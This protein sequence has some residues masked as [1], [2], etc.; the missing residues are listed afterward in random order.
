[1]LAYLKIEHILFHLEFVDSRF[2]EL[3]PISR[4]LYATG[5][6]N[7]L[8]QLES[9]LSIINEQMDTNIDMEDAY[10]GDGVLTRI[11]QNFPK[12]FNESLY[13]ENNQKDAEIN[14]MIDIFP[15]NKEDYSF[16]SDSANKFKTG[17]RYLCSEANISSRD[18]VYAITN[19]LKE[20]FSLIVSINHKKSNIKD[21]QYEDFWYTVLYRDDDLFPERAINDYEEWKEEHDYQDL[22]VLKD[23][24]TQ[25]ILKMLNSGVFNYDVKPVNRELDNSIIEIPEEALEEGMEIPED[26]KTER[27]RFSK[28]VYFKKDILCLDYAKLGKYIYKHFRELTDD[29]VDGLIYFDYILLHIHD[30]MA[31]CNPKLKVHLRFYE[32]NL[33]EEILKNA[34][35]VIESCNSLLTEEAEQQSFLTN[36]LKD[37]FYGDNK[38]EVQTKLKGQSKY[39]LLCRMLGMIKTTQ[40]AFRLE[41]TTA[42]LAEALSTVVKKPKKDSLDD[43][44]ERGSR[45]L[46]SKLSKWTTLYVMDKL[47][48]KSERLFMDIAQK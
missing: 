47:G 45:E 38:I 35:T 2:E 3:S 37:A 9:Q 20:V 14:K 42:D 32:D 6:A 34:L 39:T 44:I 13:R 5:I 23:K 18:Y 41:V 21:Y 31:V 1:M 28:Y 8:Y 27:A 15:L 16:K 24:R 36:Y 46:Q 4:R 43:Y 29:Q 26:I 40:K 25:E 11:N 22:Q 19:E 17:L 12:L 48:N 10:I 7:E 30:D 33:L